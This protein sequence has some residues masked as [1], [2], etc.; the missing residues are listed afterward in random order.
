[1]I[2]STLNNMIF[3]GEQLAK[4]KDSSKLALK[5][6]G[7]GIVTNAKEVLNNSK[8][9]NNSTNPS[10]ATRQ[11]ID[12]LTEIKQD[13][14]RQKFFTQNPSEC[15]PVTVGF[16]AWADSFLKY[17]AYQTGEEFETGDI[18]IARNSRLSQADVAVDAVERKVKSWARQMDYNVIEL[19]QA[20]VNGN[21]NIISEREKSVKMDWDL[22]TQ[23]I[24]FLGH[25]TDVAVE[26][27]YTQS[28]T[29]ITINTSL[30]TAPLA[31][32]S[33]DDFNTVKRQLI[34]IFFDNSN[35]TAY[36]DTFIMPTSDYL[37]LAGASATPSFPLKNRLDLLLEAFQKASGNE[38]FVIKGLPYGDTVR[39][40]LA[41]QRY[42]LYKN[43]VSVLEMDIPIPYTSLTAETANNFQFDS[44]SYGRYT[45]LQVYRPKEFM[46][47]DIL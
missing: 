12:T 22:G 10:F 46:Y 21:W 1:M 36:P 5:V 30:I 20:V 19:N 34:Q 7:A 18:D 13:V 45:G 9:L 24:A 14:V 42:I 40:G 6:S 38:N 17:R 8:V 37:Q 23:K 28:N 32:L 27:L 33:D 29:D 25:S 4:S 26:G 15:M 11:D 35:S 39:S 47:F 41:N 43:E 44:V 31:S 3:A 16:G 2:T